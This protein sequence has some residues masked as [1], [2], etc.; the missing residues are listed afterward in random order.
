MISPAS[1]RSKEAI[2]GNGCPPLNASKSHHLSISGP[3]D[4]R[5]ALSEEAAG[6]FLQ[7][8]E[9]INDLGITVNAAF[10]SSANV[11]AAANKARDMLHFIY[12]SNKRDFGPLCSAL[13]RP[14]LDYAIQANC[15]YLKKD[16]K[17][18]ERIQRAA[19]GWVKG[20]RGFTYE[21]R[22]RAL[23]LQPLRKR[24]LRNDL[25]LTQKHLTTT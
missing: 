2:A 24:R 4:L 3:L 14:H 5:I 21:E 23:K 18:P 12:L 20:L 11:L 1:R 13:V 15:P 8:C 10:T 22:F 16:I 7:K 17:H 9:Q 25:A 6:K 19:T